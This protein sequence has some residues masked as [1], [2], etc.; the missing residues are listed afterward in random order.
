[1]LLFKSYLV[2]LATKTTSSSRGNMHSPA[3]FSK[4]KSE[5]YN[6]SFHWYRWLRLIP[7][8][9]SFT[10]EWWLQQLWKLWWK[11][12]KKHPKQD[13]DLASIVNKYLLIWASRRW[14]MLFNLL[15]NVGPRSNM[16]TFWEQEFTKRKKKETIAYSLHIAH[17]D[18]FS[19]KKR[20]VNRNTRMLVHFLELFSIVVTNFWDWSIRNNDKTLNLASKLPTWYQKCISQPAVH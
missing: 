14:E 1:M 17:K 3:A 13:V 9:L 5:K 4:V 6:T 11:A 7:E 15:W 18:Q 2:G 10:G 16:L 12:F 8:T 20:E 19:K